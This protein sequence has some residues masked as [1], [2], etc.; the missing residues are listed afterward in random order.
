MVMAAEILETTIATDDGGTTVR[1]HIADAPLDD[2][3]ASFRLQ[4]LARLPRYRQPLVSQVQR[5]AIL[6]AQEVLARLAGALL[7][8]LPSMTHA[9]P[10]TTS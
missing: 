9:R 7:Q 6:E 2:E 8:D 10:Q 4:L 3:R 1:L 5:E